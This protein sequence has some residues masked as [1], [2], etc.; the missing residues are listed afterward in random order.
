[1]QGVV[2]VGHTSG[3]KG[4]S[5]RI[6]NIGCLTAK[7]RVRYGGINNIVVN[8]YDFNDVLAPQIKSIL[9]EK[10]GNNVDILYRTD[11]TGLEGLTDRLSKMEYVFAIEL[12]LNAS[13]DKNANGHEVLYLKGDEDSES[14]AKSINDGLLSL[15]VLGNNRRAKPI[16]EKANGGYLLSKSP[17]PIVIVESGFVSNEDN[18]KTL[19]EARTSGSLARAIAMGIN[20][21]LD[22]KEQ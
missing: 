7:E 9:E 16:P 22:L 1:M 12:H 6:N 14:L 5:G 17:K 21:Y 8:E 2:I 11:A 19:L 13:T 20:G 3:K 18:L 15:G 4:A 10:E